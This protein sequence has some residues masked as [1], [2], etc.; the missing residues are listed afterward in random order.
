MTG[1]VPYAVGCTGAF[2]NN[3]D[4]TSQALN[5]GGDCASVLGLVSISQVAYTRTGK[6]L[7]LNPP[8]DRRWLRDTLDENL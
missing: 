1:Y 3:P 4:C 2:A 5:W 7:T 8:L 6:D